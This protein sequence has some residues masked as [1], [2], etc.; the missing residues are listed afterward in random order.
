MPQ[1]SFTDPCRRTPVM[2]SIIAFFVMLLAMPVLAADM[3]GWSDKSVC[4]LVK[5]TADNAVYLAEAQRRKLDCGVGSKSSVG[6]KQSEKK[7]LPN[8]QGIVLYPL[9]LDPQV[10]QQL[11]ASPI[12]KT[13]FDFSPY[14]LAI[15][16]QPIQCQ[17][18]LRRVNYDNHVDG[19]LE[20]WN[21]ARGSMFLT[22]AGVKIEGRWRMGG[23]SKDSSYLKHEVNLKLTKAG[24][25]VGKMAF[26]HLNISAGEALKKPLYIEL[27][28]H[29]RSKPLDINNP[30]KAELWI[31]VE[32]WAG[33]VLTLTRCKEYPLVNN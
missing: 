15:L 22:N 1:L 18:N 12:N 27:K 30:K 4:R 20:N 7:L 14:Q 25:L 24:H 5:A 17:F 8:N 2:L 9:K 6:Q 11:L 21:M 32:D 19:K 10:K 26:F 29:K 33:G 16:P 23:L 3:S 13:E 28:P 31:D